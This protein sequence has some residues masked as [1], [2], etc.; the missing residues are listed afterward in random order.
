MLTGKQRAFLLPFLFFY[1][2]PAEPQF[3]ILASQSMGID[4][5]LGPELPLTIVGRT[6]HCQS[7]VAVATASAPQ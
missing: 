6:S 1:K 4:A 2:I 3:P 5:A 7:H